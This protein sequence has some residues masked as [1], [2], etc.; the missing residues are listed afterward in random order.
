MTEPRSRSRK[1]TRKAGPPEAAES[2]VFQA[3]TAAKTAAKTTPKN[4]KT[5]APKTTTTKTGAAKTATKTT[6][7]QKTGGSKTPKKTTG[8]GS[9]HV[10]RD[11]S[12][13]RNVVKY[14]QGAD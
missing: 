11:N 4:S 5:G 8:R 3:P 1:V 6:I 13:R 9:G 10:G 14:M 12:K 7:S 2:P